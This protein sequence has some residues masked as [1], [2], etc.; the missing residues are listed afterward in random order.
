MPVAYR[1]TLN[2]TIFRVVGQSLKQMGIMPMK[3]NI[4]TS[5]DLTC[6]VVDDPKASN[7]V[8]YQYEQ[9]K[10][11]SSSFDIT[12][13]GIVAEN[14]GFVAIRRFDEFELSSAL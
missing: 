11:T 5:G 8:V 7:Q 3:D 6:T 14:V 1:V 10:A 2:C 9:C 12:A 4:L 13:R